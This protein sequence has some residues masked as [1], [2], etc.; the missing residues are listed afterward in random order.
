MKH[1]RSCRR[2]AL[3]ALAAAVASGSVLGATALARRVDGFRPLTQAQ[4]AACQVGAATWKW[5]N[6]RCGPG[7]LNC[8]RPTTPWETCSLTGSWLGCKTIGV[9]WG[10][11]VSD[12]YKSCNIL[13]VQNG[14]TC[15]QNGG[16]GNPCGLMRK[17]DCQWTWTD[18]FTGF[19]SC[20]SFPA[21]YTTDPCNSTNCSEAS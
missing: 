4:A 21:G 2:L 20:D 11:S 14:W 7:T 19:C 13:D 15:T 18:W 16:T 12:A 1:A 8:P 6:R 9:C 3:G 5:C 10:C 17:P